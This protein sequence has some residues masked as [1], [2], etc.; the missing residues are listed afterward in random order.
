MLLIK[1]GAN[2]E[3]ISGTGATP[4]YEAV[5]CRNF[6]SFTNHTEYLMKKKKFGTIEIQKKCI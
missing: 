1:N 5:N 4:L 6:S 3:T 2:L